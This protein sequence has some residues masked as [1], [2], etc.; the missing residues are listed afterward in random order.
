M[1]FANQRMGDPKV[2]FE[3]LGNMVVRSDRNNWAEKIESIIR[4]PAPFPISYDV[5]ATQTNNFSE[6]TYTEF[7]NG[8]SVSTQCKEINARLYDFA[9]KIEAKDDSIIDI[10]RDQLADK[11][12][13]EDID[14]KWQGIKKVVFLPGHNMLDIASVDILSRLAHEEDDVYFKP[15]PVT[16]DEI[17]GLIAKKVGWN[18]MIPKNVSGFKL[19]LNCDEV[20]C[21]SASEMAISGTIL[22]KKVINVSTYLNEGAGAYHALSRLLF[23]AHRKY[24]IEE[25]QRI[26]NNVLSCEWTGHIFPHQ[27]DDEV[28]YRVKKFYDKSL[29]LRDLYKPLAAPFGEFLKKGKPTEEIKKELKKQGM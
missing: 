2:Q 11:Y 27:S 28:R 8:L 10:I 5:S 18:K 16:I 7:L 26:L 29:E 3:K 23:I 25:A 22:G 4:E 6:Y 9:S 12:N 14:K 1:K 19:L 20:Y 15:H 21:T 17:E 24:G 13:L